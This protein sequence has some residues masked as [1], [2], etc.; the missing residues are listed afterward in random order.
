MVVSDEKLEGIENGVDWSLPPQFKCHGKT[1]FFCFVILLHNLVS[2]ILS[3][4]Y[5]LYRESRMQQNKIP[6]KEGN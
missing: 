1:I 5:R 3:S 6:S 2:G 4:K